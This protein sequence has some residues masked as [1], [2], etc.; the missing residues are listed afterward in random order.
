MTSP[1]K[2]KKNPRNQPVKFDETLGA[3]VSPMF[4]RAHMPVA[5]SIS[6]RQ[7]GIGVWIILLAASICAGLGTERLIVDSR[8]SK[9]ILEVPVPI[10][11]A[12]L[13]V[14]SP[15]PFAITAAAPSATYNLPK[16]SSGSS[17]DQAETGS[18]IVSL[19]A[20]VYQPSAS[21]DAMQPG[22]TRFTG[23]QGNIGVPPVR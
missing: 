9:T 6:T 15:T 1:T 22:F 3:A 4:A 11:T 20:V 13:S 12:N 14:T 8:L 5:P 21:L 18:P 16:V 17:I 2:A 23:S 19:G 7:I 10:A